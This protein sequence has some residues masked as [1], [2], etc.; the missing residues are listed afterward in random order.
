MVANRLIEAARRDLIAMPSSVQHIAYS[1]G[2]SDPAY[3]SRFFLK[4]TGETPV[5][6]A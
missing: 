5:R 2:F 4:M 6:F 1:L 3:F